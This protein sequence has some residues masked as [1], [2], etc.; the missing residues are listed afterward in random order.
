MQFVLLTIPFQGCVHLR[1]TNVDL[2]MTQLEGSTGPGTEAQ[3]EVLVLDQA[4]ITQKA[5]QLVCRIVF[6]LLSM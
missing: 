3:Q 1:Q 5:Q 4:Q 6:R 2:C